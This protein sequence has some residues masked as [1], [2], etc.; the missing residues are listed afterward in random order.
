M[1]PANSV[2]GS[3]IQ[4]DQATLHH[5][6]CTLMINSCPVLHG[7]S[8]STN[9]LKLS[10]QPHNVSALVTAVSWRADVTGHAT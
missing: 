8:W 4:P 3:S 9:V 2:N 7:V 5:D 10:G 6:N 1:Y